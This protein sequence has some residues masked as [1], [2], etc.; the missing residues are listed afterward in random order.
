MRISHGLSAV[1]VLTALATPTI[2]ASTDPWQFLLTEDSGNSYYLNV[3][4]ITRN[5]AIVSF[6]TLGRFPQP[7]ESGASAISLQMDGNC[8]H[9]QIRYTYATTYDS[10]LQTLHEEK[11]E[12][13]WRTVKPETAGYK[14]LT[15]ACRISKPRRK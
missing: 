11:R 13:K 6:T 10:N 5:G 12:K 4:A 8:A 2:A 7:D 15:E 9:N 3:D 1:A 14:A